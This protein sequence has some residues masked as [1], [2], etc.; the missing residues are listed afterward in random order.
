MSA[1]AHA[2]TPT[3]ANIETLL[4]NR[5]APA[6]PAPAT[7]G[8]AIKN[9]NYYLSQHALY[10]LTAG[11]LAAVRE[12]Y[13]T[14]YRTWENAFNAFEPMRT[15]K[16][17]PKY[18]ELRDAKVAADKELADFSNLSGLP[19]KD[20]P[21]YLQYYHGAPASKYT[22]DKLK[23]YLIW[24]YYVWEMDSNDIYED[25]AA[26]T[27]LG[28][29]NPHAYFAARR[30][31]EAN[32]LD[33]LD[34]SQPAPRLPSKENWP[35]TYWALDKFNNKKVEELAKPDPS[36][37]TEC[38]GCG[39]CNPEAAAAPAEKL[40][41]PT[42]SIIVIKSTFRAH[43]SG[44]ETYATAVFSSYESA[45]KYIIDQFRTGGNALMYWSENDC[46]EEG[47][48]SDGVSMPVPTV[49]W[50][51]KRFNPVALKEFIRTNKYDNKLYGPYSDFCL[52]C[53]YELFIE[54]CE[55]H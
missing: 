15:A 51:C 44:S 52:H 10:A 26:K 21:R 48:E 9:A 29:L 7:F 27:P 13:D 45:S 5:P 16:K 54:L 18:A 37:D 30:A 33:F 3:A 50:A 40:P 49:G 2:A 55:V 20:H 43:S 34:K 4:K 23:H 8:N 53:P 11:E 47:E 22:D 14:L 19:Q 6:Q 1:A 31:G 38:A 36:T 12:R 46:F 39:H 24:R 41:L 32:F 28:L 42:N 25:E 17:H 35:L